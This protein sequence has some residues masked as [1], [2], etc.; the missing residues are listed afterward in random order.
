MKARGLFEF[1][2]DP[3]REGDFLTSALWDRLLPSW[4]QRAEKRMPRSAKGDAELIEKLNEM[5]DAPGVAHSVTAEEAN[6]VVSK[7]SVPI[8]WG[9]WRVLPP[10][11]ENQRE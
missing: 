5:A 11:A 1:A 6:Y 2:S 3:P 9:K 10:E 8:R 7:R 4:R